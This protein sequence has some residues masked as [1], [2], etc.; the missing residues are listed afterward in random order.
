ML[1]TKNRFIPQVDFTSASNF[2]FY[3][4]AEK[5]YEDS[6]N[7]IINEYPYDGSGKEK[8]NWNLSGT[9]LDRYI[10]EN[11]YPRTNGFVVMGY[12]YG[13]NSDSPTH[14]YYAPV[15][16]EYIYFKGGPNTGSLTSG[17][18][19]TQFYDSNLYNTGNFR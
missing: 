8:I 16:Q 18:L 19:A 11:E 13:S 15:S 6:I 9:Y 3:G 4:S 14:G 10:F 5:Y 7:Y 1:K 17:T 12:N 2:A